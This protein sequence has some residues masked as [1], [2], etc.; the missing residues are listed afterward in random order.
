MKLRITTSLLILATT[1]LYA[2]SPSYEKRMHEPATQSLGSPY[3]AIFGGANVQQSA[4]IGD[5]RS[6]VG[7][8][9]SD[10][11]SE[12]GWFAG[13]KLG[14]DFDSEAWAHAAVEVEAFY[15]HVDAELR[16][17]SGG[18]VSAQTAGDVHAAVVMANAFVKF[19]PLWH[20]RPYVG[21]GIGAAHLWLR[22]ASTEVRVGGVPVRQ[23][24]R[25]D[26]EDWTFAYQGIAGLDVWV[27]DRWT[28]FTEYHAL[29][30]HDAIGLDNYLNHL[31]G[32][33]V[34]LRF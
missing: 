27:N 5:S 22:E 10:L 32:A 33:G 18:I 29:V 16:S 6:A 15:N 28:I 19:K 23:R 7:A 9:S 1:A 31:V 14:Y 34:R 17:G 21:G 11:D 2:G 12:T 13:L 26:A 20:L 30:F 8:F 25:G 24:R 3:W 4:D